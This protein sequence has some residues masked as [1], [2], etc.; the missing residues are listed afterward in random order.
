MKTEP[1][2]FSH[3]FIFLVLTHSTSYLTQIHYLNLISRR[4]LNSLLISKLLTNSARTYYQKAY[5]QVT[6]FHLSREENV[7]MNPVAYH[8]RADDAVDIKSFFQDLKPNKY[9]VMTL[10]GICGGFSTWRCKVAVKSLFLHFS[11]VNISSQCTVRPG[12]ALISK[13]DFTRYAKIL[14]SVV[15]ALMELWRFSWSADD[16]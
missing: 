3:L 7:K 15:A 6:V 8:W 16:A 4:F 13:H 2:T 10:P 5:M 12:V 9:T 11:W 14:H 1:L